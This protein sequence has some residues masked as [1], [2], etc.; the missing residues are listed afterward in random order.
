MNKNSGFSLIE[1]V[2]VMAIIATLSAIAIPNIK[3]YMH[4]ANKTKIVTAVST[5]NNLYVDHVFDGS[6]VTIDE[7]LSIEGV[8]T[9]RKDLKLDSLDS[10][11]NFSLSDI[12]G[13][14]YIKDYIIYYEIEGEKNE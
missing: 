8:E 2:I 4:K 13:K 11:G 7:F 6:N 9:I 10:S 3:R 1:I 14:F 5:L 12:K